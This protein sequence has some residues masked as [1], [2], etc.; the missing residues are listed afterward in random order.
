VRFVVLAFGDSVEEGNVSC[1]GGA[2]GL[3]VGGGM[4]E[5]AHFS[6][7]R[8]MVFWILDAMTLVRN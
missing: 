6:C 5:R 1:L 2:G 7:W 4:G 3:G 8:A